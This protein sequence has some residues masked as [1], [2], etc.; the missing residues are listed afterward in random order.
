[1]K[2]QLL[3]STAIVS[4][5]ALLLAGPA[6][7]GSAE[8]GTLDLTIGGSFDFQVGIGDDDRADSDAS[9]V[10][11]RGYD[12]VT[13]TE[14][15]FTFQGTADNGLSYGARVELEVDTNA[16]GGNS[17]EVNGFLFGD[18]GRI[19]MGDQDGAEDRMIYDAG[20]TQS[21]VGG[22]DGD[23]DRWFKTTADSKS[24]PDITDTSDATKITYFS[25]RFSGFQVGASFTPDTGSGGTNVAN[26][27][28]G[29][30]EEHIGLGA[31]FVE[32]FNGVD[33]AV[34]AVAG[35]GD[36]EE[37]TRSG[38][39]PGDDIENYAIGLNI[40]YAG[41]TFGGSYGH[42]GDTGTLDDSWFFNVGAGYSQGPWSVSVGYLYSE[43]ERDSD[44]VDSDF[45][46][47]AVSG[48]YTVAP[49]L[50]AYADLLFPD[51][52]HDDPTISDNDATILLLGTVVSF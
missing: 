33:V 4:G 15:H 46:N 25:P 1:M 47:I 21:G 34:G 42:D 31:N 3:L 40:G 36:A 18:F 27:D 52:D 13:D 11:N 10:N 41:F 32:T 14:I 50:Y 2:R 48:G 19:E 30:F 9:K 24:F 43:A 29:A 45:R 38:S 49:G 37:F 28:D 7:A 51:S 20:R 26:D 22:I 5:A 17:D 16:D 35:F 6:V 23:V 12:F 39:D 44:S 8:T